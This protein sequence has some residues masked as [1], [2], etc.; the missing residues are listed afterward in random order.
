MEWIIHS[1]YLISLCKDVFVSCLWFAKKL[2]DINILILHK[3]ESSLEPYWGKTELAISEGRESCAF[4]SSPDT[5]GEVCH[6]GLSL[7]RL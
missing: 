5:F 2:E 6:F 7:L 1:S 3:E 4:P